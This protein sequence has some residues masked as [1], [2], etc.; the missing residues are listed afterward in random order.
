[1][2]NSWR[3]ERW[4]SLRLLTPNRQSNLPGLRYEGPDPDGYMTMGEVIEL[5]EHFASVVA[6]PPSGPA[7]TSRRCDVPTTG[8]TYDQPW[9]D[10][11]PD[12][13]HRER[14]LQ[15]THGAGVQRCGPGVRRAADAV[16]LPQPR[17]APRRRSARGGSVGDRR[18]AGGRAEAVGSAGDPL[19]RGARAV[20]AHLPRPR[21]AVVDGRV[22][23]VGR[24]LRRG[25]RPHPGPAA[26]VAAARRDPRAGHS[27]SQ[28]ARGDGRRAGGPLGGCP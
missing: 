19:G 1:M 20:A 2:A 11:L 15:P 25:R 21:R 16:R 28:R 13:G 12:G 27:R 23:R 5:I 7:W 3:R 4:D 17:T 18:A 22:G 8:T 10:P 9:R 24:A 14:C 26:A 6:A